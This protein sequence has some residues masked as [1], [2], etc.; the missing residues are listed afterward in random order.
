MPSAR[1]RLY[2]HSSLFDTRLN[3]QGEL[4]FGNRGGCSCRTRGY[5]T[6]STPAGLA[7][8]VSVRYPAITSPGSP[9][10]RF[11]FPWSRLASCSSSGI[12]T[13]RKRNDH[14]SG[15]GNRW[16]CPT[17]SAS[18]GPLPRFANEETRNEHPN[19]KVRSP[20]STGMSKV[21]RELVTSASPITRPRS[22][23]GFLKQR[24]VVYKKSR[25]PGTSRLAS[26]ARW[27][28]NAIVLEVRIQAR[29][30]RSFTTS[31]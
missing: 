7:N 21:V 15:F 2:R 27:A 24:R 22:R 5:G 14:E 6:G 16:S 19:G 4:A 26:R 18:S 20:N 23:I 13:L 17:S 8:P 30:S 11:S 3:G 25:S 10:T 12:S 9:A 29:G 1:R 28:V 31:R